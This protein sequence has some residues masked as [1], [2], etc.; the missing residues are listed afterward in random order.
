MIYNTFKD[1]IIN[2]FLKKILTNK[3]IIVNYND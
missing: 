3:P 1:S 2:L